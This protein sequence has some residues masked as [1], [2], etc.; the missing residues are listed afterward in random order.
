MIDADAFLGAKSVWKVVCVAFQTDAER[1]KFKI[2]VVGAFL[3]GLLSIYAHSE[4]K[5]YLKMYMLFKISHYPIYSLFIQL[6]TI[7]SHFQ[8][9]L[10][11]I[12]V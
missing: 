12:C 7:D 10:R 6:I 4:P 8:L 5:T 1:I 11:L 3:I 2:V 9:I